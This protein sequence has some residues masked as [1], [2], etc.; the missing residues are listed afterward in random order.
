MILEYSL[1]QIRLS[2]GLFY[3]ICFNLLPFTKPEDL[4][5]Q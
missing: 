2:Q 5:L 1:T 4:Q 3:R